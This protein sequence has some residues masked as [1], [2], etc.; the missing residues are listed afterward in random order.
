MIKKCEGCGEVLDVFYDT[1]G[2]VKLKEGD[3]TV[4]M[5]CAMVYRA[6]EIDHDHLGIVRVPSE[7]LYYWYGVQPGLLEMVRQIRAV[8]G[9]R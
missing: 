5:Y 8:R 2:S 6:V 7:D 3:F 9:I 1:D 4:C